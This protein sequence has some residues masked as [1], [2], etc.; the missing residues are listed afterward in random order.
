MKEHPVGWSKN[1]CYL[2]HDTNHDDDDD[3]DDDHDNDNDDDN[4]KTLW[5]EGNHQYYW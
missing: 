5:N 4:D 1:F 2:T 3:N